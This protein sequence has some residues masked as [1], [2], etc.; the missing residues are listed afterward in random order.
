MITVLSI[1]G[2]LI[3]SFAALPYIRDIERGRVRPKLISWAI[4]SVLAGVMT[5]SAFS[6]G[7]SASGVLSLVTCISC[8]VIV[9]LGWARGG[10]RTISSFDLA[11]TVGAVMGITALFVVNDPTLALI[12]A[13]VVDGIAFFPTLIHGWQSP[14]EEGVS[15]FALTVLAACSTLAAAYLH[16]PSLIGML[17]PLYAIVFDGAMTIVLLAARSTSEDRQYEYGSAE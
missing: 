9:L 8:T 11:C 15:A 16:G 5:Y 17:Y 6:Q 10:D 2:A 4:W 3:A 1:I 7:E 13:V 12:V 14:E